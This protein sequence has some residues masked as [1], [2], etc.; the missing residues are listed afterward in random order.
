MVNVD[1][2]GLVFVEDTEKLK[3]IFRTD[4]E[5][6]IVFN[7]MENT[8]M[9][10]AEEIFYIAFEFGNNWYYTDLRKDFEMIILKYVGKRVPYKM[11]NPP[12]FVN[13]GVHTAY[14]LLNGSFMPSNWVQKAVFLGQKAIGI[15]DMN[16]MGATLVLQKECA[17]ANI[18]H[19]FGYS[20]TVI[21]D[22]DKTFGAKVYVQSQEG[23]NNLLR[24]QKAINVD[25]QD[26]KIDLE[27]LMNRG[28][29]IS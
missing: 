10:I 8:K 7:T 25:S 27:E 14:E 20:L 3:S 24:I 13:L 21:D 29:G 15:C 28:E 22:N 4:Q 26:Q 11:D 19:V 6:K 18:T 5:G 16:T 1:G 23:M 9:L 2:L 12:E 17:E